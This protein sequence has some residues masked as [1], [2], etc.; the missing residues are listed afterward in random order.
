[1]A[2]SPWKE[3]W[4]FLLF[5]L[6]QWV[7]YFSDLKRKDWCFLEFVFL[8]VLGKRWNEEYILLQGHHG[9]VGVAGQ[10]MHRSLLPGGCEYLLF[11]GASPGR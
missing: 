6:Q 7:S 3:N 8:I 4:R 5:L 11:S 9:G 10:P 1:M 2:A